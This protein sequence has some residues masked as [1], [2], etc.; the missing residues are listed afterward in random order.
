MH[1]H[2][3]FS[4]ER[5]DAVQLVLLDTIKLNDLYLKNK[6]KAKMKSK[7]IKNENIRLTVRNF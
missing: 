6:E 7:N 2:Y 1:D 4:I 3:D 5:L